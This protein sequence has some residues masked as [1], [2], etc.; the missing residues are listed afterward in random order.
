MSRME[1]NPGR[2]GAAARRRE[3]AAGASANIARR[4]M[5]ALPCAT[6]ATALAADGWPYASLVLVACRHDASPLLLL[7]ELAAHTGNIAADARVSLLFDGTEGRGDRLGGARLTVLGT[8]RPSGAPADRERFL[9]RHASAAT[10]A[11]LGDF[12]FFHV[13]VARAHLVAGFGRIAWI[14]PDDL[15]LSGDHAALR[16]READIVTHMNGEHGDALA[17]CANRLPSRPAGAWRMTGCD[18]EGCDLALEG[19]HAR[20]DFDRPVADAEEARAKLA[21]LVAGARASGEPTLANAEGGWHGQ[22]ADPKRW[23]TQA[24]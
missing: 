12:G 11:E 14:D 8:A 23:G 10:Y 5:R 17:L 6:L 15:L 3:G 2:R 4:L 19:M 7:S 9:A 21:A 24:P 1:R 22:E 16:A 20:L 13:E 18:P